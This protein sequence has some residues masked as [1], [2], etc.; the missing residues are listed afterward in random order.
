M[1]ADERLFRELYP[2]LRRFAAVVAPVEDDPDD[3]VQEALARTLAI[4]PLARLDNPGAYLR[5][6]ITNLSSNRRRTLGRWRRARRRLGPPGEAMPEYP[7]D[8]GWLDNLSALDR[9]IVFLIDVERR[10][11]DEVAVMVDLSAGAV[12]SRAMRARQQLRQM[13]GDED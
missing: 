12:R 7:S 5:R 2:E 8:L 6:T 10:P 3:L 11:A 1:D 4:G 9:A 13:L